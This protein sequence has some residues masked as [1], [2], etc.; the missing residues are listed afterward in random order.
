MA[1]NEHDGSSVEL[2]NDVPE[3]DE[4]ARGVDEHIAHCGKCKNECEAGSESLGCEICPKWF[5]REC[6]GYNKST[7]KAIIQLE[8][9][10]WFCKDC[11]EKAKDTFSMIQLVMQRMEVLEVR[12]VALE[13]KNAALEKRV[14]KIEQER[15]K[16]K[17][18]REKTHQDRNDFTM[19]GEI[20]LGRVAPPTSM[21]NFSERIS[22]EV[23][24]LKEIE[25]RKANLI[26]TEIPE[27]DTTSQDERLKLTALGVQNGDNSKVVVE[28]ILEKIGVKDQVEVTEVTRIPQRV[29]GHQGDRTRKV[30]VKLANPKMRYLVLEKAKD[31]KKIGNG[32][33]T[34]YISPDLTK[35]QREKAYQLR[36]EKRNRTAAGERNLVIRNGAV[37]QK[38]AATQ[39]SFPLRRDQTQ[40]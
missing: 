21:S 34:T 30:L 6:V 32:W 35:T 16:E 4:G 13:K 36:V 5:H 15:E 17:E 31:V 37:V 8:E 28:R 9:V 20:P 39:P 40:T 11:N 24:E 18:E 33:E 3:I 19:G 2:A 25:Y 23:K 22:A 26:I 10:K 12:N 14:I 1:G 27:H 29:E 7:Y 38:N